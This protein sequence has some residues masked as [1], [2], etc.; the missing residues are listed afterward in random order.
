[1][2]TL[3]E[4]RWLLI[5]GVFQARSRF[6]ELFRDYERRVLRHSREADV[7]RRNLRLSWAEL[8]K[9]LDFQALEQQRVLAVDEACF[10]LRTSE[11]AADYFQPAGIASTLVA[12]AASM[13]ASAFR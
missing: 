9:L 11:L 7:D 10:D 12:S 4:N 1:M 13:M 6:M 8:R 3:D 2:K 5:R